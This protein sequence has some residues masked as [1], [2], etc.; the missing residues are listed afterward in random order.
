[1]AWYYSFTH[2]RGS[3]D[4]TTWQQRIRV[5]YPAD[6]LFAEAGG[7]CVVAVKACRREDSGAIRQ[8]HDVADA[9]T[10]EATKLLVKKSG[11]LL[12]NASLVWF[13]PWMLASLREGVAEVARSQEGVVDALDS[14]KAQ[15]SQVLRRTERGNM[16]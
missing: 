2:K 4:A 7:L 13:E 10:P 15:V 9:L 6:A 8:W 12:G 3:E 14:L 1:M 5:L 16:S 11:R